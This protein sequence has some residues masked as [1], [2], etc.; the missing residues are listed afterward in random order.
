VE[1]LYTAKQINCSSGFHE[2]PQLINGYYEFKADDSQFKF[3]KF[4]SPTEKS[5]IIKDYHE[6]GK[7]LLC[8][9]DEQL[10]A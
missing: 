1:I 4:I 5:R 10:K 8:S 9:I 2:P 6:N 3:W 7:C